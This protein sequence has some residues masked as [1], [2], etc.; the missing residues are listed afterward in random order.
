MATVRQH[1]AEIT[2]LGFPKCGTSALMRAFKADPEVDVLRAPQG[3][4]EITW[5]LIRTLRPEPKPGRVLAHKFTAYAFNPA[6]LAW[7]AEV[8]S[9]GL[10]VLCV[11]DPARA[12]VSWH[13]MHRSFAQTGKRKSH[14]AWKERD[15]YA[16]CSLSDYYDRFAAERLCYDE[17]L[18]AVLRMV[19][20]AR[21]AVISQERMAENI[22]SVRD[23][24]KDLARGEETSPPAPAAS[25]GAKHE[26]Y[27]DKADVDLDPAI[28]RELA[29]VQRRLSDRIEHDVIHKL[30]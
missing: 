10:L 27:A 14:F 8:N 17:Y 19:P 28:R 4:Y 24:L 18:T 13:N 9:A 3:T 29:G 12:L 23:Y 7:L 26:G 2:V 11:R 22:D 30:Y 16:E 6:A 21:L 5:P 25:E 15:F 20:K 1:A